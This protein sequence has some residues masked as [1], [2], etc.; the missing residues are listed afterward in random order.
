MLAGSCL[1]LAGSSLWQANGSQNNDRRLGRDGLKVKNLRDK[2]HT[3]CGIW[4]YISRESLK[5]AQKHNVLHRSSPSLALTT[6]KFKI[7]SISSWLPF[8]SNDY[9]HC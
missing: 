2:Q 9:V 7:T 8:Q 5:F 6:A 3:S 1:W 4:L